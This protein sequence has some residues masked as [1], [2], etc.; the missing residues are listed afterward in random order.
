M[1]TASLDTSGF[2]AVLAKLMS[3]TGQ[4]MR[5]VT[6]A[7]SRA[8]LQTSLDRTKITPKQE[9]PK[10][11]DRRFNTFSQG[12]SGRAAAR[13]YPRISIAQKTLNV[14]WI[15]PGPKFYIMNGD[16]YWSDQ[17]WAA[18]R[19]Q[20]SDRESLLPV[21]TKEAFARRGLPKQ[22]WFFLADLLGYALK[23]SKEV[24]GSTVR[25][26]QLREVV[27]STLTEN[28]TEFTLH[29][30]NYSIATMRRDGARIF[31]GALRGRVKYFK[32]NLE[33]GV[34]STLEKIHRAYPHLLKVN[35]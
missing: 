18:Y 11:V 24:E 19:S 15:E 27:Q 7:E 25:G 14:W 33:K 12:V 32:K 13:L 3:A 8:I 34:F 31:E 22:S 1:I 28:A 9:I 20:M 10:Q 30:T 29:G 2:D 26:R 17:R 6:L 35:S 23:A 21:A 4:P 5:E 16:R